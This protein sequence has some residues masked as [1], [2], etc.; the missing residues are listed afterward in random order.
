MPATH[1]KNQSKRQVLFC[2]GPVHCITPCLIPAAVARL[3]PFSDKF[4]RRLFGIAEG[5][6]GEKESKS[7]TGW[8]V[9]APITQSLDIL[10]IPSRW[11][12]EA[13]H[14]LRVVESA[15]RKSI[16]LVQDSPR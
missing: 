16:F 3:Y 10:A 12:N 13:S 8:R 9:R 1:H 15:M 14:L 7:R 2:C 6:R 11:S 4:T 5:K